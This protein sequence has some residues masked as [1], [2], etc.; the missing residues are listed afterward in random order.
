MATNNAINLS[1][2]GVVTYS[3]SGTFTASTL[4]QYNVL[5]GGS[6]NAI[7]SVAPSTAGIPL[8]SAGASTNPSFSTALVVGG[9][10]GTTSY[11]GNGVLISGT[12]ST[13]ALT[14]LSLTNGQIVIGSTSNPPA[15][16]T[17]TA[18]SGISVTNGA[19][20]IT[21]A[22]T[23]TIGWTVV[24]SSTQTAAVNSGYIANYSGTCVITLPSTSAVGSIIR[25]TG[26]NTATGWKIAQ[27]SGNT[28]FFGTVTTTP[29]ATGYL[30]S[31]AIYDSIELL[32]NTANADWIVLSSIGNISYN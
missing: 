28:I 32:C 15:A 13:A 25:V 19:N 20:S 22:A 31:S 18:G 30:E 27:N 26:M 29:G 8:V 14:D 16:A 24:T 17:I 1:A 9:G 2:A 11:N 4:T 12:T 7:V 5:I 21:I 3:G 6:S 23:G 10:T